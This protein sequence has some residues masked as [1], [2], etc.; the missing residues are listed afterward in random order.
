MDK[1]TALALL[2]NQL[3]LNNFNFSNPDKQ[4]WGGTKYYTLKELIIIA[5]GIK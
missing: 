5:Y 2:N 1:V 4:I 3:K